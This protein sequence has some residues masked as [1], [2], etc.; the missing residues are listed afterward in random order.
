[1]RTVGA[2]LVTHIAVACIAWANGYLYRVWLEHH[3]REH[4]Q[5]RT[6]TVD[7]IDLVEPAPPYDWAARLDS[8]VG[9]PPGSWPA[10]VTFSGPNGGLS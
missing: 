9:D 5:L 1:M 3:S 7:I 4:D 2:L 8:G 6:N 10:V